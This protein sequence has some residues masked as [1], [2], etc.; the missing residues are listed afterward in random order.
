[1]RMHRG[2]GQGDGEGFPL[3]SSWPQ[4][5]TLEYLREL[6]EQCLEL[7][8]EQA[9]LRTMP[10]HPMLHDL[11]DLWKALDTNSRRRAAACEYLLVD[12]GFADGYRWRWVSG[13]QV[14]DRE[15]AAFASFFSGPRLVGLANQIFAYAWHLARTQPITVRL[16]LGMPP[17]CACLISACSL[18]QMSELAVRH[19]GW[20]RPRWALRVSMWRELLVAAISGSP[21]GLERARMHGVQL[22]AA[23]QRAL[24]QPA[25]ALGPGQ[26]G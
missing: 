19:A 14:G 26:A 23:E 21:T 16:V 2:R 17:H 3:D 9:G 25:P 7:L 6:N 15:P 13:H 5:D 1:M 20:L 11:S 8:A 12:A 10:A 4:I 24:L 22:L 18:R